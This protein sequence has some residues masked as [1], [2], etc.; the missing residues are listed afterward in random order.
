[1][2]NVLKLFE[3]CGNGNFELVKQLVQDGV[4]NTFM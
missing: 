3:A 4:D 1:M 2:N